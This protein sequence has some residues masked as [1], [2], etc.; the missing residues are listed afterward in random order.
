MAALITLCNQ[1]LALVWKGQIASLNEGT[2]EARECLRFA[3]PILQEMADWSDDLPLG[4]AQAVLAEVAND[5]AGEWRHA[6]AAPADMA[7][8]ISVLAGGASP[9]AFLYENGRIYCDIAPVRLNYTRSTV[10]AGELTPLLA[11]AFVDELAARIAGPLTRDAGLTQALV[12]QAEVSRA[13]ALADEENKR[14]RSDTAWPS[15]A[16]QA[17]LGARDGAGE[18]A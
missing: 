4:R 5:R 12:Q 2:L 17:R 14:N 9:A 18:T 13:R 8:P 3:G 16:E 6:H 10:D 11:R 15:Q 1:A 7:A